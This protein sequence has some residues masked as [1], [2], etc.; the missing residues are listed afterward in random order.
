MGRIED[1]I[2]E[3]QDLD[4]RARQETLLNRI[5]PSVKLLLTMYMIVLTV[6]FH[7]YDLAGLLG[8]TVYPLVLFNLG[9]ISF[10]GAVYRLRL[11]LP[12]VCL[13]G[14]FN[15]FFDRQILMH[16]GGL[17]VTGGIL[18]MVTLM[19]KG[20]LTVLSSYLLI[21]TTPIEQ[22]CYALRRIHVPKILVTELLLICRYVL[23]L[24]EEADRVTKAYSL[25]APGQKG[26]SVRAWGPLLGQMLL[27]S[28]D[29]AGVLYESMRLR[30]FRGDFY[31]GRG[32][33]GIRTGDVIYLLVWLFLLSFLRAVPV[34]TVIGAWL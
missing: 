11:V 25:R 30:S 8:M 2:G 20:V 14:I 15:P 13:V 29:R 6:S 26:I 7:R 18:S 9:D 24:L 1:A 10:A 5:D 34:M 4:A 22:I 28:M 21:V 27:R 23:V 32:Q 33:R 19:L 17:A 3:Y 12:L 16:L 31:P